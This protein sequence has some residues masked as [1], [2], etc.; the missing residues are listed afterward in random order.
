[1]AFGGMDGH[2]VSKLPFWGTIGKAYGALFGNFGQALKI[3]W[4]WLLVLAV[5]AFY[6]A[7][8]QYDFLL[9]RV[10]Q[11]KPGEPPPPAIF[12]SGLLLNLLTLVAGS[13]IA[14][15]WHRLL[16]LGERPG[17]SGA[18]VLGDTVWRYIGAA[19]LMGIM[20]VIPAAIVAG[21]TMALTMGLSGGMPPPGPAFGLAF[22]AMAIL[23]V[24]IVVVA[25]RWG[26]VLPARAVGDRAL[27]F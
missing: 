18:N 1:M 13:S 26:L 25:M 3:S 2:P 24:A 22:L 17:L 15:A 23:W 14:V 9:D 10:G 4:L 20:I 21:I 19:L 16:I 6:M 27:R 7:R 12:V 8:L 11:A 5:L